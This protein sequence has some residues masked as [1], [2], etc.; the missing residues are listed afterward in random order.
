[1][2]E[3]SIENLTTSDNV[4]ELNLVNSYPL[5]LAEFGGKCL[6]NINIPVFKKVINLYICYT[7]CV[8]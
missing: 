1:M 6:V 8:D 3:E 4:F 5:S 7:G 2:S